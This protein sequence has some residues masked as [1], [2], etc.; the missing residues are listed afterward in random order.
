MS[1]AD[2]EFTIAIFVRQE[3]QPLKLRIV[4]PQLVE[5]KPVTVV[6]QYEIESN[7]TLDG[8]SLSPRQMSK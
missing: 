1:Y 4:I 3:T 7:G 5:H 2:E 8:F 6:I